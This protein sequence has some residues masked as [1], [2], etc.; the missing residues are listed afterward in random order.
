MTI[1]HKSP[2]GLSAGQQP[3]TLGIPKL[4]QQ[5]LV[6]SLSSQDL[7]PHRAAE[8]TVTEL[9]ETK[10]QSATANKDVVETAAETATAV[11]QETP[12]TKLES[13]EIRATSLL[14]LM[15]SLS[16]NSMGTLSM[17]S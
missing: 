1:S 3:V 4:L 12:E 10:D 8:T 7:W 6:I 5:T 15:P 11:D 14:L 13:L 2:L 17:K 9:E 16:P